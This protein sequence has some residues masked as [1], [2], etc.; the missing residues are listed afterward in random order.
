VRAQAVGPNGQLVDDFLIRRAEN[1]IHVQNAPSPAATSSLVIG[2][3][4]ADEAMI[5]FALGDY[6]GTSLA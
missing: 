5:S 4:I 6:R 1:S 2:R 3:M